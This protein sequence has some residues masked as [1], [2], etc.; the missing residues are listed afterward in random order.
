MQI[1]LQRVILFKIC[2]YD[3]GLLYSLWEQGW[4]GAWVVVGGVWGGRVKREGGMPRMMIQ[5]VF[6]VVNR[7]KG[8]Q[9]IC[10]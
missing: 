5:Q 7:V 8:G 6:L 4:E 9:G 1:L 3:C 2:V 10:T